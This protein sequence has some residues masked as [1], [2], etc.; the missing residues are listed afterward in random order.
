MELLNDILHSRLQRLFKRYQAGE[1]LFRQGEAA[2]TMYFLI[3]GRLQLIS[4]RPEGDAVEG[5]LE[6]GQFLGEKILLQPDP[7]NR[8]FSGMA[9]TDMLVLEL[10]SDDVADIEE[11][12]PGV[13]TDLLKTVLQ[14]VGGRFELAGFLAQCLR[15]GPEVTRVV[16]VVRYFARVAGSDDQNRNPFNLS[17]EGILKYVDTDKKTVRFAIKS[18]V[19]EGILSKSDR[20]FVLNDEDAL[21]QFAS[22]AQ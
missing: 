18:L 16:H 5:V 2:S 20:H 9:E 4:E 15:P 1:Y 22:Q 11:N 12:D 21:V 7:Y 10:T 6:M 14:V 17:E 8:A 3:N 13:M 19:D